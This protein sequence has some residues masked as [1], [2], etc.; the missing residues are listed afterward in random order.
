MRTLEA[1]VTG[2]FIN[3]DKNA[4]VTVRQDSVSAVYGGFDG[5]ARHTGLTRRSGGREPEYPRGT[6]IFNS[7]QVTVIADDELKQ[8]AQALGIEELPPEW[9]GLNLTATGI[10]GL[11]LLPPMTKLLFPEDA[12]I[13][14]TGEN[15]PCEGPGEVI[16]EHHQT[17]P[18]NAFQKAAVHKRGATGLIEREGIIKQGDSMKVLLPRQ[19]VYSIPK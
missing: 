14:L 15:T 4:V 19:R 11:T 2:L 8:I 16:H 18:P 7:R 17:I 3:K 6:E 9:L 10:V 1:L 13:L 12:V 5:D